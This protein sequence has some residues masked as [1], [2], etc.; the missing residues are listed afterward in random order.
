MTVVLVLTVD[1]PA[2]VLVPDTTTPVVA[3]NTVLVLTLVEVSVVDTV[4]APS[5]T[6]VVSVMTVENRTVVS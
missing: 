6:V 4:T 2:T 3:T 5:D 1:P